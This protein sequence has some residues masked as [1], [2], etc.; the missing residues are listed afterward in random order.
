MSTYTENT[1]ITV[2]ICNQSGLTDSPSLVEGKVVMID[3]YN[4]YVVIPGAVATIETLDLGNGVVISQAVQIRSLDIYELD[5]MQWGVK[6]DAMLRLTA[7]N[8]ETY[9]YHASS[10]AT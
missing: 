9:E 1:Y 5:I 8:L 2:S 6:V 7:H 4:T 10:R 3:D